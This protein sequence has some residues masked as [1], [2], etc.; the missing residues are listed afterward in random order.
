MEKNIDVIKVI[1]HAEGGEEYLKNATNYTSNKDSVAVKGYG[2]DADNPETAKM[3]I[4]TTQ[5]Y[6]GNED[7]NP[8]I[9]YMISFTRETADTPEKAMA[10]TD[11][12]LEPFKNKHQILIGDHK[13]SNEKSDYHT[14]SYI[15]TTN[16]ETGKMIYSNNKTNFPIAQR[17]ADTIGKPVEFVIEKKGSV[18]RDDDYK[19]YF[20]PRKHK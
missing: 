6:Y 2:V 20:Y 8:F 16:L 17:L 1:T 18:N 15:I 11:T 10:I 3:Q 12:V 14:H 5:K 13:K 7:K 4:E 19:K 9:Q